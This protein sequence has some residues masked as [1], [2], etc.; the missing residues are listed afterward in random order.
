MHDLCC[1][2]QLRGITRG[3]KKCLI[4]HLTHTQVIKLVVVKIVSPQMRF[5]VK[6]DF[7]TNDKSLL[8][9][10]YAVHCTRVRLQAQF[11]S[12]NEKWKIVSILRRL[13]DIYTAPTL[14]LSPQ[15]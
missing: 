8:L 9:Q 14:F 2:Y 3:S 10:S 6:A 1:A 4:H 7:E 13:I 5:T 15:G 11:V 12:V